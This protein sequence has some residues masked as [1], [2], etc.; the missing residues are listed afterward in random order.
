MNTSPYCIAHEEELWVLYKPATIPVHATSEQGIMDLLS[1]SQEQLDLPNDL[2]PI[3][4]LDRATSGLVLCSA[5]PAIRK[6]L[7]AWFEQHLVEKR[8]LA[9]VYGKTHKKGIIRRP[10]PDPRRQRKLDAVTRYRCVEQI[11]R[12]SL[13]EVRPETGRRHQIRRH[14]QGIGHAL[15][16]DDRYRPKR[17]QKVPGFPGRLW[18][19]AH[20]L[21]LPDG[22][23]FSSPLP[24]ELE[25]H[26]TFLRARL[27][28]R[29]AAKTV[30]SEG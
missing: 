10:L 9:L 11:E 29:T 13:L 28:R 18:L 6:E 26:L 27:A 23:T 25:E 24:S 3:H 12:V 2:A 5:D 4:R 17:P 14:L 19:H 1:W 7:G 15:V 20:E 30:A 22:R 8:Y 21:T 16:G